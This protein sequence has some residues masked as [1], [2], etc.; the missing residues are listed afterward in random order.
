MR[1]IFIG[2]K[3]HF[4]YTFLGVKPGVRYIFIG[5]CADARGHVVYNSLSDNTEEYINLPEA[6]GLH[7]ITAEKYSK[8]VILH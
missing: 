7:I 3:M 5:I 8:K 4:H 1:G 6:S 2:V